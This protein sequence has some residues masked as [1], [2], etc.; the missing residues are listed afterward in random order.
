[1]LPF[2]KALKNMLS[3]EVNYVIIYDEKTV[4]VAKEYDTYGMPP[5]R[6]LQKA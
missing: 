1:M 2:E 5:K 6:I 3:Y 4:M